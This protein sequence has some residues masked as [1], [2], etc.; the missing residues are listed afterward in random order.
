MNI[1]LMLGYY[2]VCS[3]VCDKL[4][5]GSKLINATILSKEKQEIP[6]KI[7]LS[8]K[9]NR[10]IT[11]KAHLSIPRP[12]FTSE[13][14]RVNIYIFVKQKSNNDIWHAY[15]KFLSKYEKLY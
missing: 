12:A 8:N 2:C 9:K 13:T 3:F 6:Y 14:M 11:G 10:S 5:L 4:G 1:W 7:E 15:T